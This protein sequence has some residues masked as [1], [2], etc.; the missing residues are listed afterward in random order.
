M[1]ENFVYQIIIMCLDALVP[2]AMAVV[3]T[4][5]VNFLRK[6]GVSEEHLNLLQ[7][8]Y[9]FLTKAVTST[10]QVWVDAL[11]N[12]EGRLTEEQQA[13]AR[14]K[15]EEIFRE[16]ITDSVKFAIETAYGSVDKYLAT[17]LEAAVGEVKAAKAAK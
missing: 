12:A 5:L 4:A 16:M 17:Y 7:Q 3:I 14:Q 1:E 8:A 2:L 6:K 9:G 13:K 15:T 10:N 11:K